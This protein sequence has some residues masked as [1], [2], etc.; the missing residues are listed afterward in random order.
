MTFLARAKGHLG[1]KAPKPSKAAGKAHMARVAQLS[2]VICGNP[3]VTVHHCISDRFS[4][5]KVSD[6]ETIPLCHLHHQGAEGIHADKA[7]WEALHGKDHE[8]LAVVADALAGELN[9]SRTRAG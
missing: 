7:A 1:L 6:F 8:Y 4:Q 5:R 3:E 9:P 2:C